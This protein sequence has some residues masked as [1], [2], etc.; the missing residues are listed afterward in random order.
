MKDRI[1]SRLEKSRGQYVSGAELAQELGITRTAVWKHIQGLKQEGHRIAAVRNQGYRLENWEV[2]GDGETRKNSGVGFGR[3]VLILKEASSTN[4][5][6]WEMASQGKLGEGAVVMALEQTQGKGRRGRTW[7]SPKGGLWFSTVLYPRLPAKDV[8]QLSLVFALAVARALERFSNLPVHV[9]WPNDVLING[10]KV[11]G[12]LLEMNTEFDAVKYLVAG[13][14]V[15][16]NIRS[17]D[18]PVDLQGRATS[19]LETTGREFDLK[20]ILYTILS[21]MEK[22]YGRYFKTGFKGFRRQFTGKCAHLGKQVTVCLQ[23]R[24]VTGIDRG[25]DDHGC[26]RLELADGTVLKLSSGDVMFDQEP[27]GME[28]RGVS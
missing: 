22:A 17:G 1:L 27:V 9:K 11:A 5:V 15:N 10:K 23:E 25:V 13:I 21:E 3:E 4:T 24:E 20:E 19:L 6:A 18:L 8:V 26:L 7:Q 28:D 12:I 14:G 2:V 16:V